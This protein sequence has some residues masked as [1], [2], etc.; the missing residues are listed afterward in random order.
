MKKS[1]RNILILLGIFFALILCVFGA[2]AI[3]YANKIEKQVELLELFEKTDGTYEVIRIKGNPT[4][5]TIPNKYRGKQ[6]TS[7]NAGLFSNNQDIKVVN[8]GKYITK[9]KD[10]TF[11]NCQ[12]LERVDMKSVV[13]IGKRAFFECIFLESIGECDGLKYVEDEAFLE[14][15]SLRD[16]NFSNMEY[17]G[18]RAFYTCQGITKVNFSDSIEYIGPSAFMCCPN[19]TYL[20]LGNNLKIIEEY[21]FSDCTSIRSEISLP[22]AIEYIGE[23]AF[24]GCGAMKGDFTLPASLQHIGDYAFSSCSFITGEID[25][26]SIK[27][28]GKKAFQGTKITKLSLP[29]KEKINDE[30]YRNNSALKEIIIPEGVK[31][32][33]KRAFAGCYSLE[34][35]VFPS[36]LEEIGQE[37]FKS[38]IE[39]KQIVIPNNVKKIGLQAFEW[40]SS[41]EHVEI[42]ENVKEIKFNAFNKCG[43]IRIVINKSDLDIVV[44]SEE[45]GKVA[46]Y[47]SIVLEG[48]EANI[49][50]SYKWDNNK[51]LIFEYNGIKEIVAYEGNSRNIEIPQGVTK[52]YEKVFWDNE[53]IETVI[54]PSSV[55]EIG[56]QAFGGC[57]NL[58]EV[59][60][61]EGVVTIERAAFGTCISLKEIR[62][63]DSV[64][65]IGL[66]VI[67]NC[68]SLEEIYLG[69]NL[70]ILEE[71]FLYCD[72][73][74]TIY[75]N[76]TSEQWESIEKTR[77]TLKELETIAVVFAK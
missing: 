41:L 17:V 27:Y 3:D 65:M 43:R 30:E 47:A 45:F 13:S 25:L 1:K 16:V 73:L 12:S 66:G 77:D 21:A 38:C 7:L 35:I 64:E 75:F 57:K 58:K 62:I 22:N 56:S 71:N 49:E 42:G 28:C 53:T 69:S 31:E 46:Q 76:G 2:F 48:D 72:K 26:T 54:I 74:H 9:I 67:T 32:I 18:E 4:E 8:I 39:L 14:C 52:I 63:P 20:S 59:T 70:R 40:C 23:R 15:D 44:G 5:V 51:F 19:I 55:R 50:Y 37:A 60:I 68:E 29:V 34:K 10:E 61:N 33:G 24:S 6:I 11:Y 36:T